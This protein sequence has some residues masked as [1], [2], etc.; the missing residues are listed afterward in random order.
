MSK[1]GLCFSLKVSVILLVFLAG[2]S[3]TQPQIPHPHTFDETS[4]RTSTTPSIVMSTDKTHYAPGEIVKIRVSNNLDIPVW[5]YDSEAPLTPWGI[6]KAQGKSWQ[7]LV[8]GFG[9]FGLPFKGFLDG[10]EYCAISFDSTVRLAELKPYSDFLL[11]EWNQN[12][13]P[14]DTITE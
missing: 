5:Y 6:E 13:C 3:A 14:S 1:L 4:N 10:E 8:V 11:D 9:D 2:C 12:I 7:N